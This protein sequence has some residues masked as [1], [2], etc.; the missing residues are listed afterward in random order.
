VHINALNSNGTK[1]VSCRYKDMPAEI[2][3]KIAL[4]SKTN[5]KYLII[6]LAFISDHSF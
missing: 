5:P 4:N 3:R 2:K 6:I 1:D